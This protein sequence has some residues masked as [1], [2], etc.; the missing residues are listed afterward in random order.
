MVPC[1]PALDA[2]AIVCYV[3][4][5]PLAELLTSDLDVEYS[6]WLSHLAS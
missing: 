3:E 1:E 6:I 5:V 2:I 4:L